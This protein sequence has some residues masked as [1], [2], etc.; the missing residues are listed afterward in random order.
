MC[1]RLLRIAIFLI[2][3]PAFGQTAEQIV[4]WSAHG[5]TSAHP[6]DL[7]KITLQARIQAEWHVY[8]VS[9]MP[10]GPARTVISVTDKQPFKQDGLLQPPPPHTAFDPNFNINTETYQGTV[11]FKLPVRVAKGAPS[12]AQKIVIEVLFQ[13]CNDTTCL[14]PHTTHLFVPIVVTAAG[15]SPAAKSAKGQ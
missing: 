13:T 3:L 6:G 10:G 8:S 5:Q 9:Q 1:K 4:Q 15:S 7:V 14:P 11:Q 2:A 12:G